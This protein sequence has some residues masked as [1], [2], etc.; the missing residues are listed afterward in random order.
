MMMDSYEIKSELRKPA[1]CNRYVI[2]ANGAEQG[3]RSKVRTPE[4]RGRVVVEHKVIAAR[5][6]EPSFASWFFRRIQERQVNW[7]RAPIQNVCGPRRNVLGSESLGS[8]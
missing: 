3:I 5:L 1:C 2:P 4:A 8:G 7:R 6:D